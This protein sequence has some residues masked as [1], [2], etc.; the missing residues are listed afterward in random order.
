L[1]FLKK[2]YMQYSSLISITGMGGLFEMLSSKQDGALVRSLNDGKTS[3]ISSRKHQFSHLEGIEVYTAEDNVNL[4]E[5]F[6][7]IKES[8]ETLPDEKDNEAV[9]AFFKKVYPAMDFERV[10]VSDMRKMVK[11]SSILEKNE[12]ALALSSE[13]ETEAKAPEEIVEN[14]ETVIIEEA[15]AKKPTKKAAT[16]K[17]V[18]NQEG[19]DAPKPAAK[20][21]AKKKKEEE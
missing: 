18:S 20:K 11:W 19:E 12:V 1:P 13:A 3:F 4:I 9:K 15:P 8:K 5:V 6:K 7:A 16:K 14:T 21:A 10:Y 2:G 17:A